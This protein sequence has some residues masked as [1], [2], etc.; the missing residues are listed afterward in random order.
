[1]KFSLLALLGFVTIAAVMV[2]YP[3]LCA[4]CAGSI[5]L[6]SGVAAVASIVILAIAIGVICPMMALVR[7]I[8]RK[9]NRTAIEGV[10]RSS[11]RV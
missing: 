4:V 1:M 2:R 10:R 9:A 11:P 5:L 7:T 3:E 8:W 6:F